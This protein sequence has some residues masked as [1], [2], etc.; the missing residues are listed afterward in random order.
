MDEIK[1]LEYSAC[2]NRAAARK[3]KFQGKHDRRSLLAVQLMNKET[4]YDL[5]SVRDISYCAL[6]H[7]EPTLSAMGYSMFID[8]TWGSVTDRWRYTCL[9]VLFVKNTIKFSQMAGSFGFNTVL[10]YVCG[11]FQFND[12]NVFYRTSHIPCVD[13]TRSQISRQIE[14][15]ENMLNA[16]IKYQKD[17]ILDCAISS[18]DYNGAVDEENCYCRELF[19]DFS[20]TD[21]ISVPT[22][23]N[24]KLDHVYVSDGF[25]AAGITAEADVLDDYYMQLTDH[26]MISITLKG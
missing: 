20:F 2:S 11:Y 19:E 12:H 16:D 8:P 10:R 22:Y 4:A 25:K 21:L 18:G 3:L 7:L 14:R 9:S 26:H 17:H 15:K 6:R 24:K 23:E 13:D 1:I 5:I